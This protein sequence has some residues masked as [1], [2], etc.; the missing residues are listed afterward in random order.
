MDSKPRLSRR[1]AFGAALAAA[2][3]PLGAAACNLAPGKDATRLDLPAHR[4]ELNHE[5]GA[6]LL[7]LLQPRFPS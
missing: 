4:C 2:T 3:T 5:T 6:A 7:Q 1:E